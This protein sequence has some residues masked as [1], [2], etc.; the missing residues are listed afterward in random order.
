VHGLP[1]ELADR[2][3]GVEV[4]GHRRSS[5]AHRAGWHVTLHRNQAQL[6]RPEP[7]IAEASR[8]EPLSDFIDVIGPLILPVAAIT[9][10]VL[11]FV[12]AAWINAIACTRR[13]WIVNAVALSPVVA[14]DVLRAFDLDLVKLPLADA[15]LTF[16]FLN[17]YGIVWLLGAAL[18]VAIRMVRSK[19]TA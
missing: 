16:L 3:Q 11:V 5:A 7:D 15:L 14:M 17:A 9:L 12:L 19:R 1:F 13:G 6:R 10:L 8:S 18:G 2:A 4:R